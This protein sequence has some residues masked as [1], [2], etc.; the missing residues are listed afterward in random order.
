[1]SDSAGNNAGQPAAKIA[2]VDVYT[3]RARVQPALLAALP[4]LALG[5]LILP[6]LE[7]AQRLW[8]LVSIAMTTFAGLVA[9]KAGNR[10]QP[11]L[12]E[13]W[14]GVPTT[15][16]LR[17]GS[18]TSPQEIERR[19]GEV[20]RIIG[21]GWTMPTAAAEEADPV[22]ADRVYADSMRQVVE[23]VRNNPKCRMANI[24]NR[25]YGFSRNLLGLKPLG[26][27]CAW[28]GIVLSLVTGAGV[29]LAKDDIIEAAFLLL[30]V[31]TSVAA[32]A[33]WRLVDRDFVRPSAEAYAD[34]V[35]GAFGVL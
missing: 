29:Y 22:T 10:V 27:F 33:L 30:P 11:Q 5:I 18:A 34:R 13:E 24:E 3:L 28:A 9:R 8:S 14:G 23:K 25:N 35:V 17:Y 15:A 21:G 32:L 31:L 26:L 19:H 7:D 4:L 20:S 12:Y 2:G 16:R 1:M 6:L